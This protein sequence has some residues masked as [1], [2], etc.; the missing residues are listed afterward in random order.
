MNTSF[1]HRF[2]WLTQNP[3]NPWSSLRNLRVLQ[4]WQVS[5]AP[6]G[7]QS[8]RL[9]LPQWSHFFRD[10]FDLPVLVGFVEFDVLAVAFKEDVELG[11][12]R[13]DAD[14]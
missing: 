11:T 14:P 6:E 7:Q 2:F 5:Q 3:Q 8:P 4:S 9:S 13:P 12:G 1:S 10:G